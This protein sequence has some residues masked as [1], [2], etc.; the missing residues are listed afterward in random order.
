MQPPNYQRTRKPSGLYPL[1]REGTYG[2]PP[3]YTPPIPGYVRREKKEKVYAAYTARSLV[4]NT[5]KD[6][7]MKR[8]AMKNISMKEKVTVPPVYYILLQTK[9]DVMEEISEEDTEEN[10]SDLPIQG[11][12]LLKDKKAK[13]VENI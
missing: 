4:K 13:S 10:N 1:E 5:V 7:T 11:M 8:I 3:D 9:E 2:P 6:N 12:Q